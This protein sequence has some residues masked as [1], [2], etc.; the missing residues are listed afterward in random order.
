MYKTI[1][2]VT[3]IFMIAFVFSAIYLAVDITALKSKKADV[4]TQPEV[5]SSSKAETFI[6]KEYNGKI[7]VFED[8]KAQ[9]L[10]VLDTPYIYDL[11]TYDREL[12]KVGITA[13]SQQELQQILEDYDG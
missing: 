2:R 12:L 4:I 6:V 13:L 7:A 8:A 3:V 1:K 11:P 5:Q 9:P 10:Y